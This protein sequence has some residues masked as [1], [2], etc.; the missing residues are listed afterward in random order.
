MSLNHKF[1]FENGTI[2]EIESSI[3]STKLIMSG[4]L[5]IAYEE[6]QKFDSKLKEEEKK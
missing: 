6:I 4:E 1:T 5:K 3:L 2:L